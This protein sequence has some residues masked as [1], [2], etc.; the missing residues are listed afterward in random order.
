MKTIAAFRRRVD[1]CSV[2][3][4]R[5]QR[6]RRL[7]SRSERMRLKSPSLPTSSSRP[8]ARTF[9]KMALAAE[10]ERCPPGT[11]RPAQPVWRCSAGSAHSALAPSRSLICLLEFEL[12]RTKRCS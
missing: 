5:M 11:P 8:T 1:A 2:C 12:R 3:R 7:K 10:C 4:P 6:L 9:L